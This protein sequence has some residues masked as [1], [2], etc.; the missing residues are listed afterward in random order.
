VPTPPPQPDLCEQASWCCWQHGSAPAPA[1][2]LCGG[3]AAWQGLGGLGSD[4]AARVRPP[5][6]VPRLGV[7]DARHREPSRCT[8]ALGSPVDP[9]SAPAQIPPCSSGLGKRK[10]PCTSCHRIC[11]FS[12]CPF[13]TLINSSYLQRLG[14]HNHGN[15]LWWLA[16]CWYLID[17]KVS[18]GGIQTPAPESW[19]S[20]C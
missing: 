20:L 7:V 14:L 9:C 12:S 15:I 3:C 4:R 17:L 10:L 16:S 11:S 13:K 18:L 1:Q 2:A 5:P 8:Q 6:A 19:I